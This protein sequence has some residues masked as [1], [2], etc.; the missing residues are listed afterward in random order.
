MEDDLVS[1]HSEVQDLASNWKDV[2]LALGLQDAYLENI[3]IT[4]YQNPSKCLQRAL[5]EW[6][7]QAHDVDRYG[8]PNWK[9]MVEVTAARI[10]GDNPALAATLA[11]N[12]QGMQITACTSVILLVVL[13]ILVI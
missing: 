2:G 1:V 4:N 12:H 5:G 9:K 6:L 8:L 7:K 13:L 11:Q 10:A 3:G